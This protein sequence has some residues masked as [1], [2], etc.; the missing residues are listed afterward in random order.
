MAATNVQ[1]GSG[2]EP[3]CS[4]LDA[5]GGRGGEERG[6][7]RHSEIL[8]I[9]VPYKRRKELLKS[10]VLKQIDIL[11]VTIILTPFLELSCSVPLSVLLTS[12]L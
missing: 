8:D 11:H 5:G 2:G 6:G 1:E 7:F 10:L 4:R 12:E 9:F 3:A